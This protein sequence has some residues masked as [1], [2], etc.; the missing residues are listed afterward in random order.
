[1]NKRLVTFDVVG[2]L[3]RVKRSPGFHYASAAKRYGFDVDAKQIDLVYGSVW[4]DTKDK[5]PNY[6]VNNGLSSQT[7]WQNFVKNVFQSAGFTMPV[8]D[9]CNDLWSM[10]MKKDLWEVAPCIENTLNELQS[11]GF[12]LGV[13]SNFDERLEDVL[14][15]VN[16]RQYFSVI[17]TSVTAGVE[18][19][20]VQIFEKT[21]N[22]LHIDPW[23]ALHIG[24]DLIE[25]YE[26]AWQSKMNAI[27]FAGWR[28]Y[29]EKVL[30]NVER[31]HIFFEYAEL[32]P[33]INKCFLL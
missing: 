15:A 5:Y 27:L 26:S 7:W 33:L 8:N 10:F 28:Q 19:P 25:D 18:K 4:K 22:R 20:D 29:S 12:M 14:S 21:L 9:I 6:G 24:D 23:N 3:L 31:D 17:M 1:M 2:T 11:R 13:V 32:L 30:A 16:L